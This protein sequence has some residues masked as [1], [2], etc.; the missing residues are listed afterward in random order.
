MWDLR[1]SPYYA[2]TKFVLIFI[3]PLILWS[4]WKFHP[5]LYCHPVT[6]NSASSL[7][8]SSLYDLFF[9]RY[10]HLLQKLLAILISLIKTD[11]AQCSF[12]QEMK[13]LVVQTKS[14][15]NQR[16]SDLPLYLKVSFLVTQTELPF[17]FFYT[18][19]RLLWYAP[20]PIKWPC[21]KLVDHIIPVQNKKKNKKKLKWTHNLFFFKYVYYVPGFVKVMKQNCLL[22][23]THLI[24]G[25]VWDRNNKHYNILNCINTLETNEMGRKHKQTVGGEFEYSKSL[26]PS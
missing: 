7:P 24:V 11:F 2:F 21:L 22:Y 25:W 10:H 14:C 1:P 15:V 17:S 5:P 26:G 4:Y 18:A 8:Q 13:T 16:L 12:Y 23:R 20:Y 6:I 9:L 19:F 3:L